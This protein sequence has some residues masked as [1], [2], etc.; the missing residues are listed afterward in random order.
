MNF[1]NLKLNGDESDSEPTAYLS[2]LLK[3]SEPIK[4][5]EQYFTP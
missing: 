3:T 2:R 4:K 1:T 5:Y